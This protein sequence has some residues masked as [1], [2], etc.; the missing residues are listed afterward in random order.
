MCG[1]PDRDGR[2]RSRACGVQPGE[3]RDTGADGGERA[4][5][6]QDA[7]GVRPR[8][9]RSRRPSRERGRVGGRGHPP[10]VGVA[11]RGS[12]GPLHR[13]SSRDDDPAVLDDVDDDEE[14][15]EPDEEPRSRSEL[16]RAGR[17]LE[18]SRSRN[19]RRSRPHRSTTGTPLVRGGALRPA[20]VAVE[21]RAL[22]HHAH[23]V[24]HL[25]QP[26]AADGADSEGVVGEALELLE[27]VV[28]LGAAVLVGGQRGVSSG[29][30]GRGPA[31][32]RRR[33]LPMVRH[34]ARR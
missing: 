8:R 34:N 23:G 16:R 25:A 2:G 32:T 6:G 19:R 22:E 4:A 5:A 13:V 15:D 27:R 20:V 30:A 17:G 29:R 9:R 26:P 28:A 21:A 24:E 3:D 11:R 1:H 31:G 12:A 33:R 18:R 14:S 7:P 10:T